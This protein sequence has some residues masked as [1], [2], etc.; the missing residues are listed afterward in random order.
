M[1]QANLLSLTEASTTYMFPIEPKI[2]SNIP[3]WMKF[4]CYE[5]NNS[6]LGRAAAYS[7]SQGGMPIMSKLKTQIAVPCPMSFE[8][9]NLLPYKLQ[10]TDAIGPFGI[11]TGAMNAMEGIPIIGPAASGIMNELIALI[12]NAGMIPSTLAGVAADF[13][14]F[15]SEVPQDMFDLQYVPTGPTRQYQIQLYLPCL[16]WEDSVVAG[17][18][19]RAFESLSLP[20]MFNTGLATTAR[21]YHPPLW[22]FGVGPIGSFSFDRDWCGE[23]QLSVL[24]TVKTKRIPLDVN[25]LSAYSKSGSFKPV[26]YTVGLLFAELEPAVRYTSG[27]ETSTAVLSRSRAIVQQF[28]SQISDVGSAIAEAIG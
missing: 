3:V 9:S 1:S 19:I 21:Y 8:S 28:G 17:K 26:A 5:Y 15:G 16:S 20:T 10:K 4:F 11:P 25:F 7:R 27:V 6:A 22:V 12:S 18:I 24:K 14:G 23:P 2:Q 13:I